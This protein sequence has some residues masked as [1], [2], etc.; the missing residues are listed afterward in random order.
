M[1]CGFSCRGGA[2]GLVVCRSDVD[3]L[4]GFVLASMWTS[5][6]WW[7]L[8]VVLVVEATAAAGRG[9]YDRRICQDTTSHASRSAAVLQTIHETLHLHIGGYNTKR[10]YAGTALKMQ[11]RVQ[12]RTVCA[13]SWTQTIGLTQECRMPCVTSGETKSPIA[14]ECEAL[15]N[16]IR[17]TR[18]TAKGSFGTTG[19]CSSEV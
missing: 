12:P 9:G 8:A 18:N 10:A 6:N 11:V 16:L 15:S 1:R 5:W 4:R 19:L 2:K 17:R 14:G 13:L 7:W 3:P